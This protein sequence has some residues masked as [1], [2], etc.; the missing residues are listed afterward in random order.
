MDIRILIVDDH[1]AF[2]YGLKMLLSQESGLKV[3]GEAENSVSAL[4]MAK[5]LNPDIILLDI[6]MP[7]LNGLQ[8]LPR[9]ISA[10]PNAKIIMLTAFNSDEFLNEAIMAGAYGYL[11]KS[12]SPTMLID[13]IHEVHNGY[14]LLNKFQLNSF[15]KSVRIGNIKQSGEFTSLTDKEIELLKHLSDG[16]SYEEISNALYLSVPTIKRYVNTIISKTMT[17]NRVQAVA[18]AVRQGLI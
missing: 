3:I 1:P 12:E 10:V 9:I 5:A 4:N 16:E 8:I 14:R 6:S 15:I 17:K 7:G 11:L 2:R 18:E 13:A